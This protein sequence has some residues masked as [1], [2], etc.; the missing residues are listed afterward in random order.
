MLIMH[1]Y[2]FYSSDVNV[3]NASNVSLSA[4]GEYGFYSSS[5]DA[6]YAGYVSIKCVSGIYCI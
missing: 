5:L 6:I 2:G 4:R 3:R 1:Q